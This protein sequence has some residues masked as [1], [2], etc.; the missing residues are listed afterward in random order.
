MDTWRTRADAALREAPLKLWF[1][2]TQ[3]GTLGHFF[4][5]HKYMSTT[6]NHGKPKI[7]S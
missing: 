2:R 5:G 7:T 3:T 6:K 1:P 4:P